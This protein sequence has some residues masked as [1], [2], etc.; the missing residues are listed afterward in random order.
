MKEVGINR[1][2]KELEIDSFILKQMQLRVAF[3]AL[4]TNIERFLIRNNQVFVLNPD[5]PKSRLDSSSSED[6]DFDH[7]S[8]NSPHFATFLRGALIHPQNAPL[9]HNPS[10]NPTNL[11]KS[12]H[13][14]V[15]LKKNVRPIKVHTNQNAQQDFDEVPD[16]RFNTD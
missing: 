9:N 11:P 2:Y 10:T 3:K 7:Y 13:V 12:G 15:Q 8:S 5:T 4:F 14:G 1:A 6:V 16:R